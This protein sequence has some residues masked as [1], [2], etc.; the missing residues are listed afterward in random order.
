MTWTQKE[1][2]TSKFNVELSFSLLSRCSFCPSCGIMSNKRSFLGC[3]IKNGFE[4]ETERQMIMFRIEIKIHKPTICPM[5]P[6]IYMSHCCQLVRIVLVVVLFPS[7]VL[8]RGL[9]TWS[10]PT[11]QPDSGILFVSNA[12]ARGRGSAKR[13]GKMGWIIDCIGRW[14][15]ILCRSTG[16]SQSNVCE[17]RPKFSHASLASIGIKLDGPYI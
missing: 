6:S 2:E 11:T 7:K 4:L 9:H 12:Y 17:K 5:T 16:Q 3:K 13:A 1:A 10:N 14:G 8:R 15:P